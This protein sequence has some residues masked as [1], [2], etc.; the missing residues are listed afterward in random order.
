MTDLEMAFFAAA[1][2]AERQEKRLKRLGTAG[3][4]AGLILTTTLTGFAGYQVRR[5]ELRQIEIYRAKA[6]SLAKTDPLASMVNGLAAIRLGQ[7]LLVKLPHFWGDNPVST[8]I[9]DLGNRHARF[10]QVIGDHGGGAIAVVISPDG[11][12]IVSGGEDGTVRLWDRQGQ[13]LADPFQG[14]QG[15]VYSVAISPDGEMI[16]SGGEDGMV[17]LWSRQGQLLADPFQGHEGGVSLLALSTDGNTIVS[18]GEDGTIRLWNRQGQP[19]AEP[20]RGHQGGVISVAFSPDSSTIVS[21][22]EDGTVR[23]WNRHG[24]PI[25]EPFQGHQGGVISVA[26]SPDSSTI[27]SGG[28]DGTV[29]L[30]PLWLAEQGWVNY[31]CNRIRP[32]LVANSNTDETARLAR[33]TCE[34]SA[35]R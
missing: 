21:G 32:Y 25:A 22:G 23:L 26:F 5:A 31:T 10:D 19:I 18:G 14:H 4:V 13:L 15:G 17:R 35:W 34:R 16:V 24:Q 11:E 20:F 29:R 6:E 7:N 2:Q 1:D 3:L 27:V 33:R 28:E 8:A 12:M 30:W 9:L